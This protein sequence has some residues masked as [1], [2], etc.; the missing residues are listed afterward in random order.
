[1]GYGTGA[2]ADAT[3]AD[4]I[5]WA[6]IAGIVAI[7]GG[8]V[9]ALVIGAR[10]VLAGLLRAIAGGAASTGDTDIVAADLAGAAL[11]A[12]CAAAGA[13]DADQTPR[14]L[15]IGIG[16]VGDVGV[17][18]GVVRAGAGLTGLRRTTAATHRPTA[19]IG[20]GAATV[21]RAGRD[22]GAT[23]RCSA[24]LVAA[25]A[26]A[27]AA[28]A[29]TGAVVPRLTICLVFVG[30]DILRARPGLTGL[31]GAG[32]AFDLLS[33]V[34]GD[35]TAL[36]GTGCGVVVRGAAAIAGADVIA[37]AAFTL[38]TETGIRTACPRREVLLD[39]VIARIVGAERDTTRNVRAV[40][41]RAAGAGHTLAT[42]ANSVA[43][44]GRARGQ[45]RRVLIFAL[46][47]EASLADLTGDIR[48]VVFD[49]ADADDT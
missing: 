20:D 25:A 32:S 43:A 44:P 5:A 11:R 13:V 18:T 12:A 30:A 8:G 48:A 22:R 45:I 6:E 39:I 21:G 42:A 19:A 16:A 28:E 26:R 3:D 40:G 1:M 14:A 29:G 7:G 36:A 4:F 38:A 10:P 17:G 37:A 23:S 27:L 9:D 41:R 46:V 15:V 49:T 24:D 31:S 33:A 35:R 2:A 47:L 34:V